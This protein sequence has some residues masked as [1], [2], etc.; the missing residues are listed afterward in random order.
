MFLGPVIDGPFFWGIPV[1]ICLYKISMPLYFL[2]YHPEVV[3]Q[4]LLKKTLYPDKND[5]FI[6]AIFTCCFMVK[7]YRYNSVIQLPARLLIFF[8]ILFPQLSNAQLIT[9]IAGTG[10]AGYNG[11]G[12]AATSAQLYAPQGLAVDA[13]GN[14]YI[15]DMINYRIRKINILTGLIGT[16]AGTGVFG[17][18]GDGIAATSAQ[19][20]V[21]SALAF[22]VTGDLYFTDRSNHRIRKISMTTGMISTV[23]GTGTGSYN[24]DG[25]PA[26][27]AQLNNPNDVAFDAN[28]NMFIADWINNR[29]RKVDKITGIIST[30]AGTG[31]GSYNGDGIP[32][33]TAMVN[34]PCGIIFD[35]YG[36]IY[37]A[38]YGGHRVRKITISTGLISTIA[39]TGTG[40]YN[41]DGIAATTAQLYGPA[42][43]RF[44]CTGNLFI[45]DGINHRVRKV[46][47][48]SGLIST[49][50]GTGTGGY[51]GDGIV[52]TTAQL[53]APYQV[54]F[55]KVNCNMYI[56]DYANNR[57]RKITGGFTACPTAVAPG[58]LVS[59]QV[60]PPITI[61]GSNFNAWVPVYDS[62]GKIAAE[63]NANGNNLGI[64]NTSLYTKTGPCREDGSYRL[65]LNRNISITPQTQPSS[66][67][68]SVRLYILKAELD[69]LKTAVN[70]Q[71]QPSGVA[72]VNEIDVFKNN[73]NCTSIGGNSAYP[74]A[75]TTSTY[76]ADYYLQ[77]NVSSFSSFYFANKA[78]TV[79]LPV[80]LKNFTG[81]HVGT[82]HELKWE[83]DCYEDIVFTI[84]R[85]A[86]GV[87]FNTI[88]NISARQ[89]DCNKAFYFTD[90]NIL[91]GNNYYRLRIAE[92]NGTVHY[93]AIIFLN[94]KNSLNI[95]LMNNP[96]VNA[97][98][99]IGLFS[100][101]ADPI[102][103][104]FT[105]VTGRVLLRKQLHVI[106]GTS[107]VVIDVGNFTKGVYWIYA[108][109][110]AGRS[111]V[112]KFVNQ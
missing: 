74:L 10:T 109:G 103:F 1:N 3:L 73:D 21:A 14:I 57:I 45:G 16:I 62:A 36:N 52:A 97:A 92:S 18:N 67:N 99:D 46:D 102:D 29:V 96:A 2:L 40:G 88:G 110:T 48:T 87:H 55:D 81:K 33:N 43:I 91:P 8:F 51:N 15:G 24:G 83:V 35:I 111:N 72:S 7:L 49:I 37:F 64:V 25:I 106:T 39:G 61:N 85:S 100:K 50:A 26:T 94:S 78:L 98:L 77:V 12:I 80:K 47:K 63:I 66:G 23:A 69:S 11:D 82:V 56:G 107:H 71:S 68:V 70:S 27:A 17:Y 75:A 108:V 60:L 20:S 19:I 34:G 53:N 32:A 22:D 59:C 58:N 112:V 105:D 30:I 89:A 104:L 90:R 93:S 28:G 4:E 86:D 38:E 6:E 44:D 13:Y 79:I 76:N 41:G 84:E 101:T 31:T 54:Y 65:Y 5:N 95:R 42:Y 9:T